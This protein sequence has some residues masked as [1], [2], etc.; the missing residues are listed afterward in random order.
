MTTPLAYWRMERALSARELNR[1]TL[2]RQLL[3]RRAR[4]PVVK[5]VERLA[6][7]QAQWAPAPYVGLWSRL[8]GFRRP[9]LERALRRGDAARGLLMRGTVHLVS[10]ADY[11]LFATALEVGSLGWMTREAEEIARRVAGSLR[12]FASEPRTRGEVLEWLER[13]HGVVSDGTNRVWY[14]V[15]LEAGIAHAPETSL[16]DA[17]VHRPKFVAADRG[18]L[19]SEAARAEMVRRYLAAFGPATR[20]EI[21]NW[22]GMKVG[23]FAESLASLRRLRDEQG[24]QLLD[25]PRAPRPAPG[26]P[27]PV[28]FLPKFDNVLLDRRRVLPDEY[29][30]IVVRKNADVQQTF[31][32]DGLVAGIWRVEQ[33]KVVTEPFAP[34]PR[35]ARR[36]LD[37]EAGRLAAWLS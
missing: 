1:A 2:A 37:D 35:T 27:A 16:W 15:R 18:Q 22:S 25:L 11:A 32:V 34:L 14:A 17:P 28:R 23:D 29:R 4:L 19:E 36:E 20:A 12:E 6:G 10:A 7:L 26:T 8:E 9:T 5:A 31:L 24:R 21:A 3:L 30:R 13:E 33:G